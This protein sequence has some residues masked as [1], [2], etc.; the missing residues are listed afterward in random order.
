MAL[1]NLRE[2]VSDHVL[3]NESATPHD[4]KTMG[5]LQRLGR[6]MGDGAAVKLAPA[7]PFPSKAVRATTPDARDGV[8][9][10]RVRA[11]VWVGNSKDDAPSISWTLLNIKAVKRR[12]FSHYIYKKGGQR[13]VVYK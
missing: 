3:D 13:V 8:N 1:T 7:D 5:S 2:L 6:Y 4:I 11:R 10:H 12:R 9:A